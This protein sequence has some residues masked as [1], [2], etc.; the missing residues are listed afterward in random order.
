MKANKVDE[1]RKEIEV[2]EGSGN[3]FADLGFPDADEMFIKAELLFEI[4]RIVKERRLTQRKAAQILGIEQPDVSNLLRG[5]IRGFS[6]DRFLKF[7]TA[8]GQDVE[9]RISPKSA[10]DRK[11]GGKVSVVAR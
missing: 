4:E 11:P 7:L 9:I 8:L 1:S 5:R 6:T 3:V 2:E 10:Q